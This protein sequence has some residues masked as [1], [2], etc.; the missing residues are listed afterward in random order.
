[1]DMNK[2]DK[3]Y[4][5]FCER[6]SRLSTA[7]RLKVGA[8]IVKDHNILSYGY[9]GTPHGFDNNCEQCCEGG[10]LPKFGC[11]HDHC[12]GSVTKPEVIHA[13]INAIAKAARQGIGIVNAILYCNISPC[14]ECAKLIIQ[15]G[16]IKVIY[17][18]NYRDNSGIELLKQAKIEV[19]KWE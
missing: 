10:P 13:E 14:I 12:K 3:L 18:E 7:K 15:S 1:M 4:I 9:N 17:K 2:W 19:I 11:N 8:V 5:D 16:I 6:V